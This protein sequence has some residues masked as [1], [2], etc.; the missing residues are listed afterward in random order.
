MQGIS[1]IETAVTTT[2]TLDYYKSSPSD[3]SLPVNLT[4]RENTNGPNPVK[5]ILTFN[6]T[7][8]SRV[9]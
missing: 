2:N 5:L 3:K 8:E 7:I 4:L 6:D 9:L 1:P